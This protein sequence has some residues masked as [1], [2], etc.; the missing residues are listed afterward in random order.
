MQ[1]HRTIATSA[2][3]GIGLFGATACASNDTGSATAQPGAATT[4]A[5][6]TASE[7][8]SSA[9]Q[10]SETSTT[11]SS[12]SSSGTSS[13]SSTSSSATTSS[14]SADESSSAADTSA[15]TDSGTAGDTPAWAN[16]T[17]TPGTVI[18]TITGDSFT[19]DVYQVGNAKATKDGFFADPD[20]NKPLI[21]VGD[22][23][24][25]V[26]FVITNTSAKAIPLGSSLISVDARYDDWPYLQ[27]MDSI[28]DDALY[29]AQEVNPDGLAAGAYVDPS[30]YELAPGESFSYGENFK[31][32]AASP[33]T[34]EATLTP[35]DDAGKLVSDLRQEATASG[36]I[37]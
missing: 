6:S 11:S 17:T 21:A 20:T 16:P 3:I 15:A 35:V 18:A 29:E 4:G 22:E 33:I 32:Q 23:L 26:N 25:F 27:G 36:T 8:S 31:Y 34:F 2:L 10:A 12:S 24:V 7:T 30:I 13:A 5:S 28:T 1:L 9:T 19:V 14:S 37:A